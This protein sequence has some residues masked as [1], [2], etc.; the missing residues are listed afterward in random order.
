MFKFN[1]SEYD[2]STRSL[3]LISIKDEFEASNYIMQ[4]KM[5]PLSSINYIVSMNSIK[6]INYEDEEGVSQL[7]VGTEGKC[8]FIVDGSDTKILKK[9][10]LSGIPSAIS[11]YG[12]YDTDYRV[13]I[14][15][16]NEIIY[17]LR[18]GEI[19][20]TIIQVSS[21]IVNILRLE[22]SLYVIC[23]NSFFHSYNPTGNKNF[24]IKQPSE[25]YCLEECNMK[26]TRG[27]KAIL[28]GLK[29]TEIRLYNDK[30]LINVITIP[31][32]IFGMKFGK[33]GKSD[34]TLVV[35]SDK[36]SIYI[37][38]LEKGVN[39]EGISHK[40]INYG[41]E[42]STLNIPKK[43]TMFLDLMEREKEYYK[44]KKNII[45]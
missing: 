30:L 33:L 13:H 35:C 12:A 14:A 29:N 1:Y 15:C 9:F 25:I 6:K 4:N 22:K 2:L 8:I 18:N 24:S 17:T 39:L 44:S 37:K 45:T 32:T 36:G 20:T 42:E 41:G 28:L 40:K 10:Q 7:V 3:E 19:I 43:T 21:K 34:E 5:E 16:R 38:Q 11:C 23:M 31:E 26:K 27:F